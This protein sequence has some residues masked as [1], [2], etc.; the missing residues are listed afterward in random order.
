MKKAIFNTLLAINT[1]IF[2]SLSL[3][4]FPFDLYTKWSVIKLWPKITIWLAKVIYGIKY[5]VKGLENIPNKGAIYMSKHQSEWETFF[6]PTIFNRPTCY[7]L[8]KELLNIPF[9]GWGLRCA[10]H[11]PIDRKNPRSAMKLILSEGMDRIKNNANI[12][13]FPEGTR[14]PVG[15]S[16]HYKKGGSFLASFSKLGAIP[17]AINSGHIWSRDSKNI[18]SGTITVSIGPL[19]PSDGLSSEEHLEK[20]QQWIE[21]EMRTL[22]PEHY[23]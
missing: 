21:N 22:N 3:V 1:I 7:V 10:G 5:K 18:K 8:K 2:G 20:V 15:S 16:K 23:V 12:I 4:L 11:I 19:I 6:L 17:I 14:T 13:I 9:L